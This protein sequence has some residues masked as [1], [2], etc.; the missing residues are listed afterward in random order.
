MHFSILTRLWET[1]KSSFLFASMMTMKKT[2]LTCL[3]HAQ[4]VIDCVHSFL[5]NYLSSIPN[6]IIFR[7]RFNLFLYFLGG[8]MTQ[9]FVI[10]AMIS[11][12]RTYLI[13]VSGININQVFKLR[14]GIYILLDVCRDAEYKSNIQLLVSQKQ[15]KRP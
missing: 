2:T 5:F 8:L 3:A 15:P 13:L 6:V 1:A 10:Y 4:S 9:L 12:L 11:M 7:G 14:P